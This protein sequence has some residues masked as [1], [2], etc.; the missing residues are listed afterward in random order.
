MM[1]SPLFQGLGLTAGMDGLMSGDPVPNPASMPKKTVLPG[2]ESMPLYKPEDTSILK[3][4]DS[5]KINPATGKP[6][7]NP[8]AMTANVNPKYV[9]MVI[10]HAVNK[11]MDPNTALAVALQETKIGNLNENMGSAWS[12][13]PD[14]G[15][16]D[17]YEQGANSLVKALSDKLS[18]AKH[19]GY[20]KK[21]EAFALQAYNGYGRLVPQNTARDAVQSFYEVPTSRANPLNMATNPVYG[22]TIM[23]L[24]DEVIKNNPE[25]QSLIKKELAGRKGVP[26]Q[27]PVLASRK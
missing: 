7:K 19:L 21:G 25:L 12:T 23:S 10:K 18:Y 13:F 17:P 20:D 26:M 15:I 3:I 6:F 2:F 1:Q 22:K 9:S 27:A 14:E 16:D 8:G 5:R 11:G 4:N 24:R